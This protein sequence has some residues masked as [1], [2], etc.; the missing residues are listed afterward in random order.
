MFFPTTPFPVFQEFV[1]VE[2]EPLHHMSECPRRESTLYDT[3][4][5]VD[6]DLILSIFRVEMCGQM[7]VP[8]HHDYNPKESADNWHVVFLAPPSWMSLTSGSGR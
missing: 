2:L 6:N 5:D 7:V 4:R 3:C 8:V 1:S